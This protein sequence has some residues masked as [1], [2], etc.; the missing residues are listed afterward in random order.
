MDS[1]SEE[2]PDLTCG[3]PLD[4]IADGSM[5]EGRVGAD[6]VLLAR[7]GDQV[8]AIGARCTH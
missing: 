2:P 6:P 7:R 8:F 3:I 4:S 5:L 1:E